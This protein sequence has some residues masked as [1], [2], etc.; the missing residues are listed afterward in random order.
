VADGI[1]ECRRLAISAFALSASG[2]IRVARQQPLQSSHR[3]PQIPLTL[4]AHG[5]GEEIVLPGE[6]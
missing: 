1:V 4:G 2:S 3:Q 6:T 5:S